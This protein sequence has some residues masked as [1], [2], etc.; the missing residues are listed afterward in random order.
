MDPVLSLALSMQSGPSSYA[1]LLGSGVSRSSGIPTGWEIVEDLI[2]RI[3]TAAGEDCGPRPFDW[4]KDKYDA[5]PRYDA[6]LEQIARS[7]HD[8]KTLLRSYFEPPAEERE[9]GLKAPAPA[10]RA[11]AD[12]VRRGFVRVVV[13]TNFDRLL[14]EALGAVGIRP[15]V[16]DNADSIDGVSP[17]SS[18]EPF[19]VKVHGDYLDSRIK[20]TAN[21][22]EH[23]DDRIDGLLDRIL[24][25]FGLVVCGWSADWDPALRDALKRSVGGGRSVYWT[26]RKA[27]EGQTADLISDLG[28]HP[29]T[30]SNADGFFQD[31]RDKIV[32]LDDMAGSRALS[33]AVAVATL[34]R[35]LPDDRERIR[36][37]DSVMGQAQSLKTKLNRER[38][39]VV[40]MS[41]ASEIERMAEYETLCEPL[42]GVISTGCF[43]GRGACDTLWVET[44]EQ[45]AAPIDAH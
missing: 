19:V 39:P 14:E 20:N 16:I 1:L 31:L 5:D 40:G 28:A 9:R 26:V 27:A 18:S 3:A 43:H 6:L 17:L 42:V 22:L 15:N 24:A 35:Y 8:R 4:Y 36:L 32:A 41:D 12:L 25:D 23:Y 37:R 13:T 45:L 11:I 29:V 10:H 34:K 33:A 21:E 30:I 44:I 2:C 7:T 38:F